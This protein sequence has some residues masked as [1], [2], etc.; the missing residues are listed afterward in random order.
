MGQFNVSNYFLINARCATNHCQFA[1]EES[2][3]LSFWY[4]S[5][6]L[7]KLVQGNV[8]ARGAPETQVG[9][10]VFAG[11]QCWR[12]IAKRLLSAYPNRVHQPTPLGWG[13]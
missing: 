8:A 13:I 3:E 4:K 7:S 1:K 2:T 6:G 11:C 12:L 5:S 10:S 9:P